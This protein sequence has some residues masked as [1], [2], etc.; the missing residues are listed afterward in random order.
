MA[1]RATSEDEKLNL[2][3][4]GLKAKGWGAK[5]EGRPEFLVKNPLGKVVWLTQ[6]NLRLEPAKPERQDGKKA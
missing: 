6:T 4:K 3:G 5:R 2:D 1:L